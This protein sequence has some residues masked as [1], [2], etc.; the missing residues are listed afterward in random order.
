MKT[1]RQFIGEAS[2]K[3]NQ[4]NFNRIYNQARAAGDRFPE[5]TAAQWAIES[6][7]GSSNSGKNNPF[8]EK[9]L[10]GGTVRRTREVGPGGSYMTNAAFKDFGSEE[11]ATRHRVKKWSYKYGD[12]KDL[13]TAAR[14]LQ[15]PPGG[16]IPG[17]KEISHGVYA[18]DPSYASAISRIARDYGSRAKGLENNNLPAPKLSVKTP[19]PQK[20]FTKT[21]IADKGG[22]GGTVSTH[23]AYQSKLGGTKS[24]VTRGDTGTKVIR[25]KLAAQ[26]PSNFIA[27]LFK[28]KAG[29]TEK[30]TL[31]GVKGTVTHNKD[32]TRSF[33]AIKPAAKP[34]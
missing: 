33:T 8:G 5:L 30:A 7:W 15:I 25:A 22:K 3:E 16:K 1:F 12:A 9:T 11:E 27:A 19:A 4:A 21:T 32:G 6:G 18:T 34:K 31:G 17:T 14:N 13:E 29:S 2:D 23:T 28:P 10:S 20:T 26:K 24:T